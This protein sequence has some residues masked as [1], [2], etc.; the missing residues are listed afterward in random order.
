MSTFCP[1]IMKKIVLPFTKTGK[2]AEE[3]YLEKELKI[4]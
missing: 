3:T 4:I 2:T 1:K